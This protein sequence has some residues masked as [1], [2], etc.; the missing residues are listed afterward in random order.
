MG[1]AGGPR[2]RARGEEQEKEPPT[3]IRDTGGAGAAPWA[4]G[5]FGQVLSLPWVTCQYPVFLW[6]KMTS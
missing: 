1:E 2:E 6:S 3:G 4:G 5:L